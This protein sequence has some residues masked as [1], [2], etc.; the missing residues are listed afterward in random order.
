MGLK[1]NIFAFVVGTLLFLVIL[2]SCKR[3][4]LRPSSVLLWSSMP[5]FLVS[6]PLLEP[7]YKWLASALLGM[8]DARHLIYIVIILFLL[9]YCFYLSV[10]ISQLSDRIQKL[11]SF[12][13]IMNAKL[14][15]SDDEKTLE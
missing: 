5:I 6:I 15:D 11:I 12:T 7:F 1:L 13:A 3:N 10:K 8:D 4:S 2:S 9:T 14:E